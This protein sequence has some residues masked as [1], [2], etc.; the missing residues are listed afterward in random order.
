[1]RLDC[2]LSLQLDDNG[3]PEF[4]L[5]NWTSVLSWLTVT[6]NSRSPGNLAQSLVLAEPTEKS[7]MASTP[8]R[9]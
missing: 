8:A 3:L 4:L 1:L 7:V 9:P 5:K 2:R 6:A